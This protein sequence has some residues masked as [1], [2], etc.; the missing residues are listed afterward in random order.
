MH[1]SPH[2]ILLWVCSTCCSLNF[3]TVVMYVS[4]AVLWS[5]FYILLIKKN[6][7]AFCKKLS[8]RAFCCSALLATL[9][10]AQQPL[11]NCAP[12]EKRQE[13]WKQ[14]SCISVKKKAAHQ[15]SD[16]QHALEN[17]RQWCEVASMWF[18]VNGLKCTKLPVWFFK[19]ITLLRGVIITPLL[20]NLKLLIHLCALSG[21]YIIHGKV[22]L[23]FFNVSFFWHSARGNFTGLCGRHFSGR[24]HVFFCYICWVNICIWQMTKDSTKCSSNCT[25]QIFY[26]FLLFKASDHKQERL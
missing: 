2:L 4:V 1:N 23:F 12:K 16:L 13:F 14:S 11:F 18:V 3:T 10:P 17:G 25:I 26:F 20:V 15:S 8:D 21:S 19:L 9:A 5:S 7:F 24:S 6:Q 22:S